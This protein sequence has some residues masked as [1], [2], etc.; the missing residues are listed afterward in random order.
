ME[1]IKHME[2]IFSAAVTEVRRFTDWIKKRGG[3]SAEK[4]GIRRHKFTPHRE[5]ETQANLSIIGPEPSTP[6]SDIYGRIESL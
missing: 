3:T 4:K 2:E 6:L 1:L 5:D